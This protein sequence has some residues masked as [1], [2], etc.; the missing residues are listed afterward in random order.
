MTVEMGLRER[1]KAATREALSRAAMRL[2]IEHGVE[3]VTV[4]AIAAAADVSARTFHNYFPGKEEAIVAPLTDGAREVL[5]RLAQR[6]ADE[7]VW[8]SVRAVL[9]DVLV[10]G[11]RFEEM[12]A[13]MRIVKADPSLVASQLCG[14][15]EMQREAAAVIAARTGTDPERDLYPHL[16]AGVMGLT[17]RVVAN[18]WVDGRTGADLPDL[19]DSALAQFR[20]GLPAPDAAATADP[21]G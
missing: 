5:A 6:P 2:A 1:K 20:A 13:L 14:L 15:G 19:I 11:E 7:P 21:S 17:M 10:P 12:I 8:D 18:L 3:G 16:V 9:H 4:D